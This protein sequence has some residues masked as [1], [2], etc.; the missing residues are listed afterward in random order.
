MGFTGDLAWGV[1]ILR[2]ATC[3]GRFRACR[4]R[5]ASKPHH[6][7]AFCVV[8]RIASV[9]RA[10]IDEDVPPGQVETGSWFARARAT[11]ACLDAF[12]PRETPAALQLRRRKAIVAW[13]QAT[14]QVF[15]SSD[16]RGQLMRRACHL[17][18]HPSACGTAASSPRGTLGLSCGCSSSN[19]PLPPKT[20]PWPEPGHMH[21]AR[22]LLKGSP[23]RAPGWGGDERDGRRVG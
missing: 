2:L 20:R 12:Y 22:G 3:V 18:R 15:V 9:A 13:E 1:G 8:A 23:P 16:V 4:A 7:R 11:G 19:D 21:W 6:L 14:P 17:P 10:G 5:D